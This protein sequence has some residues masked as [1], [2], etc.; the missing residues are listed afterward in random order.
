VS[1]INKEDISEKYQI[2]IAHRLAV[3]K[4][5]KFLWLLII[6]FSLYGIYSEKWYLI[7]VAI[8]AGWISICLVSVRTANKVERLTG[9]SYSE[10]ASIWYKYRSATED[11]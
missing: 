4:S 9:L 1:E 7:L 6:A 10:Q 11:D 2:A 5:R 8:I 3:K